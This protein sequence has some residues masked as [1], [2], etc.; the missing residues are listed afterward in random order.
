LLLS[1]TLEPSTI[2][3]TCRE[4]F[5]SFCSS[6]EP[7]T[8]PAAY[9]DADAHAVYSTII[10]NTWPI[11]VARTGKLVIETQTRDYPSFGDGNDVC[12][13]PDPSEESILGPVL[14]S[15][16]EA[17]KQ[18]W[19]LQRKFDLAIE[20]ELV[21]RET[22]AAIFKGKDVEGWKDFYDR[23]PNSGGTSH[24][25]A[26]GFNADKTLALVYVGHSCG[27]LCGGGSYHL[28]K[29]T[30]DKWVETPWKGVSCSWA[31]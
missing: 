6:L 11:T 21:P 7:Q 25:S 23:Y 22:I 2:I 14:K 26:V 12:L 5:E 24:M 8:P 15:Y 10:P 13:K 17:N 4:Y 27:G 19:L 3:D 31:S 29:K 18:T 9:N 20:Y 1:L 30:G 16:K 28:L